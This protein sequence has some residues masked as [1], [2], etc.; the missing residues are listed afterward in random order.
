MFDKNKNLK[1]IHEVNCNNE[2]IKELEMIVKKLEE[3]R[4]KIQDECNHDLIVCY[5]IESNG[6]QNIRR[7]KC[8]ICGNYFELDGTFDMFTEKDVE[9]KSIIDMNT[10]ISGLSSTHLKRLYLKAKDM[11]QLL[12][13]SD[14][15]LSLEEVKIRIF[16]YLILYERDLKVKKLAKVK[17][18]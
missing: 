17:I 11:L 18:D 14:E 3:K 8:V 13:N 9:E 2:A 10:I 4:M 16:N 12:L 1:T 15:E 5:G 7:G 6:E